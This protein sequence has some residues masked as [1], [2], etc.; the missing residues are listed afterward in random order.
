M[1]DDLPYEAQLAAWDFDTLVR[2]CG[3]LS[4]NYAYALKRG[5]TDEAEAQVKALIAVG[6]VLVA[7]RQTG[8]VGRARTLD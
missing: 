3:T 7:R 1:S 2:E 5:M 6:K 4:G 8:G